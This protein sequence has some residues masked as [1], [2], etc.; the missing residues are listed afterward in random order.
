[1]ALSVANLGGRVVW[2]GFSDYV[3]RKRMFTAYTTISVPLYLSVPFCVDSIMSSPDP[4]YLG[5]FYASTLGIFS[6]FGACYSTSPAY[7]ADLFGTKFVGAIHGRMLTASTVGAM[8]G[9]TGLAFLRKNAEENAIVDLASKVRV[10]KRERR[11]EGE[12]RTLFLSAG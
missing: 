9:P 6:F 5:I 11:E 8:L 7:E 10:D 4:M 3:G 2:A 1:M 12:G